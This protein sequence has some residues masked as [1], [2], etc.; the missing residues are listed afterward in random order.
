MLY[1][2]NKI[3]GECLPLQKDQKF[4]VE[5]NHHITELITKINH[6]SIKVP[7]VGKLKSTNESVFEYDI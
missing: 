1:Y 4:D 2:L 7:I 3:T 6:K 5:Y